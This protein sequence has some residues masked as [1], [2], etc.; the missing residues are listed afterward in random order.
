MGW[1][2]LRVLQPIH[3]SHA[4]RGPGTGGPGREG[5]TADAKDKDGPAKTDG[6]GDRRPRTGRGGPRGPRRRRDHA[7]RT[8]TDDER[9]QQA[10]RGNDGNGPAGEGRGPRGSTSSAASSKSFAHRPVPGATILLLIGGTKSDPCRLHE[11]DSP[12]PLSPERSMQSAAM[13]ASFKN[14][15]HSKPTTSQTTNGNHWRPCQLRE[16]T[17]P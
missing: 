4:G 17:R 8:G 12:Q 14:C 2:G 1:L 3:A 15:R 16:C 6:Q 5:R 9:G 10:G 11:E 13:P 7:S